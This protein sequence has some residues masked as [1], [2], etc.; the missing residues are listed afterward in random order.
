[1]SVVVCA[2]SHGLIRAMSMS[3]GAIV[4]FYCFC[5]GGMLVLNKL[6]V[7]HIH[8]PAFVTVVQFVATAVG[9]MAGWACGA[10]ELDTL[11]WRKVKHF[12]VYILAFSGG[13]WAN[14]KVLMVANVETIIVFRSCAP[15]CVS[16][17]D[18]IFY[19]RALPSRRS[20]L[21]M[22]LIV[23]GASAYVA[24]DSKSGQTLAERETQQAAY[25]W[26]AVWFVL[27]IFQLTYGKTLV[28][29]LGLQ[30]IWSPV[31]YTNA[32]A[33]APTALIGVVAGDFEA[34]ATTDWTLQALGM[35]ALSCVAGIGISW[36][37]FKCQSVVTAT[38]YTVVGV[39]NKLLT[40]LINV[41]IWDKHASP[42][43]IAALCVCL[44]GGSLYQQAPLRRQ[45]YLPVRTQDSEIKTP[46]AEVALTAREG[47]SQAER[48]V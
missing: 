14:M 38:A 13:T 29:G 15:I 22:V 24:L 3:V 41:L 16:V 17:L 9:V 25:T 48:T 5:S 35:L 10:L 19:N 1:M 37:G 20:C 28:S 30:S 23:L 21:A 8:A 2:V 36:S 40:V 27:L 32:L 43:G 34:L 47:R 6:A 42:G 12:V 46:V 18:Y 11:E 45:D 39:M 26:V 44:G 7:H 31:L 4:A 33:I